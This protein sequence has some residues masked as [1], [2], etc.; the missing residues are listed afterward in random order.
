MEVKS[1]VKKNL[2]MEVEVEVEVVVVVQ[3][4]SLHVVKLRIRRRRRQ[5]TNYQKSQV[6]ISWIM[7]S[8]FLASSVHE[9]SILFPMLD[10]HPVINR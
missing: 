2:V 4:F 5:L 8:D 10:H 6:S 9:R 1:R 7:V 3:C